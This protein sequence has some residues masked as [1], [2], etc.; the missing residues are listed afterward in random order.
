M[1]NSMF[2]FSVCFLV[3]LGCKSSETIAPSAAID[4]FNI[5]T[6]GAKSISTTYVTIPIATKNGTFSLQYNRPGRVMFWVLG[7]S[8]N[9]SE[10][11]ISLPTIPVLNKIYKTNSSLIQN[12]TFIIYLDNKDVDPKREC[13]SEVIFTSFKQPGLIK[14]NIKLVKPSGIVLSTG[15]FNFTSK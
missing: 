5:T 13:S 2:C 15:E 8:N 4:Y 10:I 11:D 6:T 9:N 14:G 12:V 7:D 3:F 1:K